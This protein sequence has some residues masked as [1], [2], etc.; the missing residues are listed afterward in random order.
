MRTF[1]VLVTEEVKYRVTVEAETTAEAE[2]IAAED[3]GLDR[4]HVTVNGRYAQVQ[5]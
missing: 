4:T 3:G 1:E 2:E 5:G